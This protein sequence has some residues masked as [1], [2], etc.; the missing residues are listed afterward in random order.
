MLNFTLSDLS[1]KSIII[2]DDDVPSVK[3]YETL[4]KNTGAEITVLKNGR[5]FNDLISLEG[6]SVD[7]VIMDFLIPYIN[8]VDCIKLLRKRDKDTPV[9]MV[10]A[11]SSDQIRREAFVAGC[12]EFVLKPLFPEK[13]LNLIEK[14]LV[15]KEY[16]Q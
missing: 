9:I 7:F 14:Y 12:N 4:L 5:E 10:T 16:V 2:V 15:R 3:Y 8:G 1:N 11:Y 13:L 6:V